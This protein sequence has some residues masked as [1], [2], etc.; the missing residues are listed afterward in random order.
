MT[1]LAPLLLALACA[2]FPQDPGATQEV[3]PIVDAGDSYILNFAKPQIGDPKSGMSLAWFVSA[4]EQATGINF[5]YSD[6]TA[7]LLENTKIRLLG[8]KVVPKEEF[9]SF[10]QMMMIINNFVCS[11]VG[12]D[13]LAVVEITSLKTQDR[14]SAK[15]D[16]VQVDPEDLD[17]YEDQPATL[18]MTVVHL[19][20]TD[21]RQLSNSMRTMFPDPNT[22]QL[23]PAGS[24]NSMIVT[25]FG[26][27]VVAMVRM[28]K[29]IDEASQIEAV[30]PEFA[31]IPLEFVSAIEVQ[32]LV[33][34]LLD[35][36]VRA[37]TSRGQQVQQAQGA[38]GVSTRG[39][40][41]TKIMT[42]ERTN[43][44]LVMAMPE[45]MP[46]IKELVAELDVDVV[47]RERNY[48]IYSLENVE[49]EALAEVLNDFLEDATRME[50]EQ[51]ALAGG[52][53]GGGAPQSSARSGRRSTEFV[54]VPDKE[55]NSLLIAANETRY[56]E[57][58]SLITRLDKRQNQVLIETALI[59]LSGH[60]FLDIGVELGLA[61]IPGVGETG[62]F[63][64]TSFGLSTLQD[65]DGDGIPDIKVPNQ[66]NGITAGILDGDDFSLPVLISLLQE[67]RK[68]DVLNVPSVLVND[69]GFAKVETKELQPT[70]QITATGGVSGQTQEN[71]EEYVDAGITMEISPSISA[72]NYLRLDI[73][74]KVSTFIGVPQGAIPPAKT[75]RTNETVINVP[76]GDTMVIGGIVIDNKQDTTRQV[77]L[78]GDIPIIGHLFRRDNSSQD[79]TALY[80]FVT[81][82]IM[83]D[84]E[85]AD[86][87]QYSYAK[88]L[89]AADTIGAD[90]VRQVDPRFGADQSPI[91]L[92]GFDVPLY[93][94]PERGEVDP[95]S[96]GLEGPIRK[97]ELIEEQKGKEE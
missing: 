16:A 61:D 93:T 8:Q 15:N 77:P 92:R 74:L 18:I 21:V 63:G 62:G 59:E 33:E 95:A 58:S 64:L 56:S 11:K 3:P 57:L 72:R 26:S 73:Y 97:N 80:F 89:E 94:S 71:F 38:T 83:R 2:A 37:A 46:R 22:N 87:A 53:P 67:R 23:L 4:C 50:A 14:A 60:D 7:G 17:I 86:L 85:F 28:L 79:R 35:A 48:H 34:E 36:S 13:H 84:L 55:S 78:L 65:T 6:D 32:G 25:G 10:F 41:E 40:T 75:E 66:S 91:D 29:L 30:L 49:A 31:V 19:P 12:P 90:R 45:D 20:N 51:G 70:T 43:S 1:A 54:V 68:A 24:T 52:Q 69:N 42:D 96:V 44:L 82:H 39:R 47:E 76:D 5:T 81:P 9:Y 27:N 88:K